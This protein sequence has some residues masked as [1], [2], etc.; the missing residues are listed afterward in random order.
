MLEM[1]QVNNAQNTP[2]TAQTVVLENQSLTE[3]PRL[4]LST[5]FEHI[6]D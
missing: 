6:D 4:Q 5:I 1:A 3:L 2:D